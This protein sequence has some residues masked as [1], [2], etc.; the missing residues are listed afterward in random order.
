MTV[1]ETEYH[2]FFKWDHLDADEWR[3]QWPGSYISDEGEAI[4]DGDGDLIGMDGECEPEF[5]TGLFEDHHQQ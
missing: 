3:R 2:L 5:T 4:F 1:K